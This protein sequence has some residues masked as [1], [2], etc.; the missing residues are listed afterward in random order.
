MLCYDNELVQ[1]IESFI[2]QNKTMRSNL[3]KHPFYKSQP[4]NK[5]PRSFHAPTKKA[6]Q[7]PPFQKLK[8]PRPYDLDE[9][10]TEIKKVKL[11]KDSISY[12]MVSVEKK[13]PI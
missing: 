11:T 2:L 6:S 12:N 10:S 7:T 9:I 5:E 8:K 13:V 4:I 1:K 3:A